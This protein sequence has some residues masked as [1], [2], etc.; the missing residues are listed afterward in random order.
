MIDPSDRIGPYRILQILGEGGMGV[1]YQAEQVEPVRRMV[2]LK[3]LR[4]GMDSK[5]FIARFDA[6]RQALAMMDHPNIAR[7]L[8]AGEVEGRPYYV[9]ELVHGSSLSA[10]CD[11][12]R[13]TTKQRLAIFLDLCGAVHHAHQR[14][15]IHRDLKPSNVLVTMHDDRPVPKVIDFGI[16]KAIGHRLTDLTLV[17][18][19][20][21][22]IG[23]PA[24]MS[25][26]QWDAQLS[27]IDTRTDIYSLGVM[28]YELLAGQLPHDPARLVRAGGAA[29]SIIRESAVAPP[30]ARLRDVTASTGEVAR[31]RNTDRRTLARDL[32]GDLDWIALKAI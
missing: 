2:A 27:D 4:F 14:G 17:T 3:V 26:E 16:A 25:P 23:T 22:T 11:E 13:L 12:H 10:F 29:P 6:E 18:N 30:S 28:L 7:V 24:Y 5:A 15:I 9:M 32:R 31:L 8:D 19:V 1:V 20:G 21:E